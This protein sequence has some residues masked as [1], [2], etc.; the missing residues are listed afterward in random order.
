[1][2]QGYQI[3]KRLKRLRQKKALR[4]L[5]AEAKLSSDDLILPYFVKEGRDIKEPISSFPD[6][7]RLSIDNLLKELEHLTP[8]GINAVLL[9]GIAEKKNTRASYAYDDKGIIQKALRE[10]K[11]NFPQLVTISDVCLCGYTDHGHCGI[12]KKGKDG[13]LQIDNDETLKVLEKIALSHAYAGVDFVAPSGMIDYQVAA[14]RHALDREGFGDVGILSYSVK[15]CS[16]FYG[17]FREALDS[18]PQFGDRK[19]YQMDYRN[20]NEALREIAEDIKEGA[21]IVMVK[22]ALCYLD[23]IS[24]IKERFNIPLAC[25][26]VSGEYVMIKTW[27]KKDKNLEKAIFLEVLTAMKRAGADL[28]I[29]YYAKE[30]AEILKEN[31]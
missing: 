18:S 27:A 4:D 14:I 16:S 11:K 8:L 24:R 13:K 30:I 26:N 12:L 7:W 23:I 20:C 10:I 22:P 3:L 25:Y 2:A 19:T 17:P 31:V 28:I 6:V 15:Y 9:F 21:D 5:V 29:T 1:M